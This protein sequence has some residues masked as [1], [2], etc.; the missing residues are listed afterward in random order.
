M[1]DRYLLSRRGLL[2][3]ATALALSPGYSAIA[4]TV[5]PVEALKPGQFTWHPERS[6]Y[7]P[8]A[9]VVSLPD[10]RVYVY[11]NGIRIA[12]STCSTGKPGH[13]T[14]TGV[15]TILQKDKNHHSSTYN[16]APM[17][18]MNRL[19][20][21]GIALHA[22]QLPGYP[23]SHGCVRLPMDFSAKLFTVTHVGTPVI[24]ADSATFPETVIH[25]G[26]VLSAEA[27]KDFDH[28]VTTLKEKQIPMSPDAPYAPPVTSIMIS[29]ADSRVI[30]LDDGEIVADGGA[31]ILQPSQP[32]GNHVFVLAH[33]NP[34]DR[35]LHWK[36]IGYSTDPKVAAQSAS[37]DTLTRIR[38]D[39]SI[40]DAIR[41]RMKPGVVLVTV[42]L[43]LSADSRTGKDFV[44]LNDQG[45][46]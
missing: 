21:S 46:A 4:D 9:I 38:A 8:V 37:Q 31:T 6:P 25:P 29:S 33:I 15:F 12:V 32:L 45:T 14:P 28:T 3:G 5:E 35:E 39:R 34:D 36:P 41:A 42:D 11:R 23:A 30:I 18:N 43:P 17:P 2:L 1:T 7:G 44:I 20:W 13:D 16:E 22:G 10:Q 19:T 24:I 27:E 26:M 40:N